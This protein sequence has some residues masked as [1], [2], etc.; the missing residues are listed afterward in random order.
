[1]NEITIIEVAGIQVIDSRI[2]AK[3]LEIKHKNFLATIR[4][5]QTVIEQSFGKVA[6]ETAPLESGQTEVFTHLTEDQSIFLMTLSRNTEKV[7][8][9]K[10]QLVKAFQDQKR[11]LENPVDRT[12]YN[13]LADRIAKLE[14]QPKPALP[15]ASVDPIPQPIAPL[16]ERACINRLVR[17]YVHN[18][19][20]SQP[21]TQQEVY[22][23]M[24][25][26]LKYRYHYDVKAR[27]TKSGLKNKLDQIA[28]DG[29]MT[30]LLAICNHFLSN[31]NQL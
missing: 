9:F 18:Q 19:T 11:Q 31:H 23:W 21:K 27:V 6:F 29:K 13:E 17:S 8:K 10:A 14:L 26:E 12:L 16:T 25:Q 28:A 15:A 5:H 3:Q 22:R 20:T 1:M 2:I 4:T 7:V 30:E 24:Y